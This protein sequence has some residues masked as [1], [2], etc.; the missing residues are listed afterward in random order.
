[1][2]ARPFNFLSALLITSLLALPGCSLTPAYQPP[3][4][5]LPA[6]LDATTATP[7]SIGP[8]V[9]L[10]DDERRLLGE[11]SH[12]PLLA[13][14]VSQALAGNRDYRIA[15]L[16]VEQARSRFGLSQAERWPVLGLQVQRQHQRFNDPVLDERYKQDLATATLG[17][18]DFEL[19]FFGRLASLSEQARHQLLASD[20]GSQAARGALVAE[21]AR[22][23]LQARQADE[24]LQIASDAAEVSRQLR[25][26]LQTQVAAGAVAAAELDAAQNEELQAR[27]RW[28]DSQSQRTQAYQALAWVTGYRLLPSPMPPATSPLAPAELPGELA[29]LPSE[30]LLQRF[31]VR[32]A[33]QRLRAADAGIGAARAAFFPSIRLSTGLGVASPA[34]HDLFSSGSGLRL[35]SPSLSL[36]LFDGG[37]NQANLDA[38]QVARQMAVADYQRTLINAFRDMASGLEQRR[39]LLAQWQNLQARQQL[40]QRHSQRQ[41]QQWQA[42]AGSLQARLQARLDTLQTSQ[43]LSQASQ[44]L[45]DNH[46]RLYRALHGIDDSVALPEANLEGNSP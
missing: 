42:G 38:A 41:E 14:L 29:D 25:A 4:S 8:G 3:A 22:L 5:P 36:P 46:L 24:A 34:L 45:F 6:R 30:R 11:L 2:T 40:A 31:D 23:Y 21:V 35:L 1:M 16:K 32:A 43:A 18:S 15:Q 17:V 9:A 10:Q 26:S 28:Q 44:A 7:T 19:D 39:Q 20:L 37:R 33:E 12:E 13:E 27:Q